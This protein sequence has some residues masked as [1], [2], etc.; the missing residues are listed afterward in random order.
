MTFFGIKIFRIFF[1]IENKFH[2]T[3]EQGDNDQE[4]PDQVRELRGKPVRKE[5]AL[6]PNF[7]RGVHLLC[8]VK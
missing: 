2:N 5:A 6:T 8:K 3:S 1:I 7:L 4:V